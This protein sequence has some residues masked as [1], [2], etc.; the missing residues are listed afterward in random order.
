MLRHQGLGNGF[1]APPHE[2]HEF[3][4]RAGHAGKVAEPRGPAPV[5]THPL[6][7]DA[8]ALLAHGA[9][10]HSTREVTLRVTRLDELPL[11]R[12][13]APEATD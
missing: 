1:M 12:V 5:Q 8:S 2:Q 7:C 9:V 10:T 4:G 13:R 6:L 3:R 11:G